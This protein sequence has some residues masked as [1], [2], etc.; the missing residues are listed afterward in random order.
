MRNNF[1]TLVFV[2][3]LTFIT[4]CTQTAE[5]KTTPINN[6]ANA[7]NAEAAAKVQ[8]VSLAR[9]NGSGKAGETV[10]EF[11][12]N[13]KVQHVSVNLND[14]PPGTKVQ[15]VWMAVDA[16][17]IKNQRVF[18]KEMKTEANTKTANFDLSLGRTFPPGD[19]KIEIFI[20]EKLAKTLNY[21]VK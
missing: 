9:D 13:E 14:V 15:A 10:T 4:A 11:N 8:S 21:K 3:A 12:S 17:G 19:Y 20:N 6:A 16:G 2:L 7:E 18:G 1:L 5:N